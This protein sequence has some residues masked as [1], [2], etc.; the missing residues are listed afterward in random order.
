MDQESRRIRQP[1][2][3]Y[4]LG[5]VIRE[6]E[7]R[8]ESPP[9]RLLIDAIMEDAIRENVSDVHL[10]PTLNAYLVRLRIDGVLVETV[11]LDKNQGLHIVR[12]LK[13]NADLDP[14]YALTP[15][16]GRVQLPSVRQSPA[17][18]VA[19][20]PTVLGEKLAL[21]LVPAELT[22][23]RLEELGLSPNDYDLLSSAIHDARGMILITGPTG[24]GKTTTVYALLHQL[25]ETSRSIV[26][27]EEPVEYVMDGITQ[28]Q[29]N[30][31]QGLSFGE[32]VKSLLRLDPDI[33]FMGEMRDANS[34]RAAMDA[35]GSGHIFLS[36]LHARDAAGT[37]TML[38]NFG[39]ADHEIAA[40][41]DL[42]IAQRLVRKL[43]PACRKQSQPTAAEAKWMRYCGQPV[44]EWTWHAGGCDECRQTGYHGRTGIFEV[45]RLRE[46]DIDLILDHC[47]E[48]TFRRHIRSRGTLSLIED[49]LIK[50]ATG[51]TS[52]AE[53]QAIG[54][55]GFFVPP[56]SL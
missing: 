52:I 33:I 35:A 7:A 47:D 32:G 45:H 28:I 2:L 9:T 50:V 21:R 46:E 48:H 12:A 40:T 54:G 27:I 11:T 42:I 14:G 29:V 23:L 16:E 22:R 17:V 19:T 10:E 24:S 4:R 8:N 43:C 39:L 13:S 31:K 20:V 51:I 5:Q 56:P 6:F 38:R 55:M 37:V 15:Q 30:E 3:S 26:S 41:L 34:A 18:R 53:I 1:Q 44:P 49:D 25:S 36:T